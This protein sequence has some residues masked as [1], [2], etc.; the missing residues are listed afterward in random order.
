MNYNE[1]IKI[2]GDINKS[3]YNINPYKSK[4]QQK[5]ELSGEDYFEQG[6]YDEEIP[7]ENKIPEDTEDEKFN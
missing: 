7:K 3:I 2:L 6:E 4:I 5:K 1:T